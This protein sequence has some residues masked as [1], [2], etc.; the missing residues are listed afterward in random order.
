LLRDAEVATT[1]AVTRLRKLIFE[2]HPPALDRDG[3]VGGLRAYVSEAL[4]GSESEWEVTGDLAREPRPFVQRLV[5]R[6]ARE[7][8]SNAVRHAGAH[9]ITVAVAWRDDG[10]EASIVDDGV[11]FD[12]TASSV[13]GHLGLL[14]S[15]VLAEAAEGWWRVTSTPG[16]GAQVAFWIPDAVAANE[17]MTD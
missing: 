15:A 4:A 13:P 11:G 8:V 9:R 2:L 3:L 7:A 6:L 5:Y 16:N 1:R 17:S 10:I 12:A 14:N